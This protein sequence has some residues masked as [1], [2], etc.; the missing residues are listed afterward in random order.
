MADLTDEQMCREVARKLG[1]EVETLGQQ[2]A[3]RPDWPFAGLVLEGLARQ[4]PPGPNRWTLPL[5]SCW[6]ALRAALA[7]GKP[8]PL[9]IILAADQALEGD[10]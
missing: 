3:C 2:W 6:H 9:A 8:A 10:E 5:S 4:A 7:V 1:I